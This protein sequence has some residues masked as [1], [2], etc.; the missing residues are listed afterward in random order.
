MAPRATSRHAAAKGHRLSR[1]RSVVC[2]KGARVHRPE[3]NAQA[4]CAMIACRLPV[5]HD[6]GGLP[7]PHMRGAHTLECQRGRRGGTGA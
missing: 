3:V 1:H 4:A 5:C 7:L 2:G 6:Q